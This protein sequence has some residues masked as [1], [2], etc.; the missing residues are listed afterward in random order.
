M[1]TST[2][3]SS[4]INSNENLKKTNMNLPCMFILVMAIFLIGE[5]R[6]ISSFILSLITQLTSQEPRFFSPQ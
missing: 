1:L 6:N 3:K 5:K 2:H 4:R